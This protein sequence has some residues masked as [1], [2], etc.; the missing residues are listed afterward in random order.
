MGVIFDTS[1]IIAIERN[2]QDAETLIAGRE[3]ELFGISVMSVAEL[4]HGVERADTAARKIKRQAFVEKVIEIFP[5]FPFDTTTARIYAKLWATV[6]GKGMSVGAHDL[7][8]AATAI[9]L[10]YTVVTANM[11]DFGR[12][13]GLKVEKR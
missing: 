4:L 7:M 11:R 12:I 3:H 6:S 5:V 13:D 1:E 9:A 8:I 10:D 2:R